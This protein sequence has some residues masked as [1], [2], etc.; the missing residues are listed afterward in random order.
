MPCAFLKWILFS[1]VLKTPP[2]NHNCFLSLAIQKEKMGVLLPQVLQAREF[3][4]LQ[5]H[6]ENPSEIGH[7][8]TSRIS[9]QTIQ[10]T[11][12]K[13]HPLETMRFHPSKAPPADLLCLSLRSCAQSLR[14]WG[15]GG[16]NLPGR[17]TISSCL[18]AS[19]HSESGGS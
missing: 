2:L 9:S 4:H 8:R 3:L 17:F 12:H 11:H 7:S 1:S 13:T 10:Y 15:C 5:K 14:S 16:W 18:N 19:F 6:A